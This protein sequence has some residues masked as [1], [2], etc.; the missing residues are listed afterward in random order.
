MPWELIYTSAPRG[1]L[2]GRS[3]FST[4]K[5]TQGM[6]LQLREALEGASS[7]RH[8]YPPNDPRAKR[9]P[10]CHSLVEIALSGKRWLVL[11]RIADAGVDH[12][13]R[14]NFFAHHIAFTPEESRAYDPLRLLTTPGV[15]QTAWD[16][17][18]EELP[19]SQGIPQGGLPESA[20]ILWSSKAGP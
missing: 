8:L 2:P 9:N 13:H 20:P 17:R 3:G 19:V 1:L 4:V 14:S 7:Y 6:P 15:L 11:S 5:M 18:V 10:V 16:G 12:T